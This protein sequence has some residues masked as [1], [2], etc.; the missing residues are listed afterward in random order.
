VIES[1]LK[2]EPRVLAEPAPQVAVSELADSSIDF[3]VRPWVKTSD[4]WPTRFDLTAKLMMA[5]TE[6]GIN[7]PYTSYDVYVKN[8]GGAA[9]T[10]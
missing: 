2:A 3:V 1:V 7:V 10:K 4:Y 5:F 6:N 8:N 9:Q